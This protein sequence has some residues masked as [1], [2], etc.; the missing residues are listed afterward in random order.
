MKIQN[1]VSL[2][3]LTPEEKAI[4]QD[5][6]L[7]DAAKMY[8]GHFLNSMVKAMRTTVGQEDGLV[9]RNMAEKIFTEQLDQKTV[10]AWTDKGG[11][12][13]ADLIYNQIKDRYFN[14]TKK[15]FSNPSRALP[16]EPR[17]EPHGLKAPDSMQMKTMPSSKENE[18]SYR[19]EVHDPSG[20]A[21]DAKAPYSGTVLESKPL[22]D[23]WNS[24]KLDHGQGLTS[25]LT[26]P[27]TRAEIAR[28]QNV[29]AGQRLGGLDPGR[30]V[31]AWKLD[32]V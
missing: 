7:R 22:A 17:Q 29:A 6:Q 32:W 15:D 8:E 26:F 21:F 30:P 23:N 24:V 10:D 16:V 1:G 3:P 13:I 11:V 19:F 28:G 12:G 9:K 2:K 31:L 25:E 4:K 18:L 5:G 14:T 20:A 27:G